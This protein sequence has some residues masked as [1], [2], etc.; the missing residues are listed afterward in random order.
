MPTGFEDSRAP[1]QGAGVQVNIHQA[2]TQLSKL[3]EQ[4]LAGQ[5]VVIARN[6]KPVVKLVPV[7]TPDLPPRKPG[8]LKGKIWVAP[9]FDETPEDLIDEFYN[10]PIFPADDPDSKS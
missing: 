9:D 6:G 1:F 2:K 8:S 5:E 10:N 7:E 3:I 4:A